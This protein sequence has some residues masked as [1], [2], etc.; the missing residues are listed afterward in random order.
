MSDTVI[1]EIIKTTGIIVTTILST[2]AVVWGAK[3]RKETKDL[4][5]KVDGRLSE[6]L[7]VSKQNAEK[8][9]HM[10]GV[11]EQKAESKVEIAAPAPIEL[12]IGKLEVEMKPPTKD[13]EK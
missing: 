11:A 7:E 4:S 13:E 2:V 5:V 3:N 6:L 1:L 10:A 8:A 9:G 12:K